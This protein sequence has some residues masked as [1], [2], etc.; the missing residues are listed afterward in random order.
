VLINLIGPVVLHP[1]IDR[2]S[3]SFL[4]R[5]TRSKRAATITD[6]H[7][8][9]VYEQEVASNRQTPLSESTMQVRDGYIRTSVP[10]LRTRGH[11]YICGH[12]W[13]D[14]SETKQLRITK[15]RIDQDTMIVTPAHGE[16]EI[17][18][19]L[20]VELDFEPITSTLWDVLTE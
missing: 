3:L 13:L 11:R 14:T 7:D 2:T 5:D 18:V 1:Y 16:P 6:I 4:T 9:V 12:I 8:G 10:L 17:A 15:V 20:G 19:D